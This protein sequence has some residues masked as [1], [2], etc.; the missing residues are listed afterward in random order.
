MRETPIEGGMR[1]ENV[2]GYWLTEFREQSGRSQ[3]AI[4]VELGKHLDKPWPR[5]AVSAA[6]NG[7]RAFT[8]AELV[9]FAVVLECS[10]ADLV[11][12]PPNVTSIELSSKPGLP[13]GTTH[14]ADRSGVADLADI[15]DQIASIK[16]TF[17]IWRD[18]TIAG[19]S[20]MEQQINQAYRSSAKALR[21]HG[22]D[23]FKVNDNGALEGLDKSG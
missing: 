9:A 3:T 20:K 6:E 16:A 18:E 8:A 5:Q 15:S 4:G 23:P 2:V 17:P 13:V 21:N 7:R 11:T 10:V 22:I 1:I 19:L 12:P 14:S